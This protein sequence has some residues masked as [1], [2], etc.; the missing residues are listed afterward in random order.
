M[1][2]PAEPSDLRALLALAEGTGVFKPLEIQALE[3]VLLDYHAG[4][5]ENG[6]RCVTARFDAAPVGF[7]YWAPAPMTE[8]TWQL[9]WI[10]VRRDL[11][12]RGWGER[13]LAHCEAEVRAAGGRLLLIETSSL[14]GYEPTRRFYLRH[15]Y[16]RH[17]A[18]RDFYADGDDL[19]VFRKRLRQP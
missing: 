3:E 13:L 5:H 15:G 6:H 16:E 17:A 1:L 11:Q 18:T 8:G 14:A 2:R 9:W 4:E 10:A 12:G 7:A 19:I